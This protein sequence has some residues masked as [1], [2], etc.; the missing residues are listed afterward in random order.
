M[1][2]NVNCGWG[3]AQWRS[4]R[5]G[6]RGE[7]APSGRNSAPLL[8]RQ[9]THFVQRSMESRYFESQSAPLLTP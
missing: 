7:T 8:P 5:G 3:G 4:Q 2:Q 9:M 1:H 6:G